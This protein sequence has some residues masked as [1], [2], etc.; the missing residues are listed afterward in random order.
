MTLLV[1]EIFQSIQG[2]SLYN[3]LRCV[4]VRLSGCNLRCSYCDTRYAY[5]N[6][7]KMQPTEII[8]RVDA[9]HCNLVEIT[10]GEPLFQEKTPL[11]IYMLIEKGY[12]V[13]L[14]TNGSFDIGIVDTRCV[15]IMDVK[16]PSSNESKNNYTENFK[17]I[18]PSDQIKFVIA[19]RNDYDFAKKALK[20]IPKYFPA[21]NILFSPASGKI[22]SD[23]LATWVL[24]DH[25]N[26]RV[27]LQIHKIIWP[28][29]NKG[30]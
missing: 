7:K 23:K 5:G 9:Y 8:S 14:E 18:T 29:K 3:G 6:G 26:I 15:K 25:L 17:K 16:C 10:G 21:G 1:N 12:Q 13:L 24:N 2:E 27:H 22:P 20:Q 4:F 19:N 30:I 11:L 28:N